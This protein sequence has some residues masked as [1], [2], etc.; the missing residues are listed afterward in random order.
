[1]QDA[2]DLMDGEDLLDVGEGSIE[3]RMDWETVDYKEPRS[4]PIHSPPGR[5]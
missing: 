2:I 3:G 5:T 1:L 4:N